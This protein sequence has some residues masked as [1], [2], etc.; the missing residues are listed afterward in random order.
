MTF[1]EYVNAR[2]RRRQ[3]RWELR[4]LSAAHRVA[5]GLAFRWPDARGW[6]G[7]GIYVLVGWVI[8]LYVSI[9]AL[10]DDE[11][12]KTIA[13]LIVG[14]AFVNSVVQWAFGAT[15]GGGELAQ[16]NADTIATTA[17]PLALGSEIA[18][19]RPKGTPEDPIATEEVR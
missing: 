7:I 12:F 5:A 8:G 18:P 3:R 15:K 11:F 14:T 10:R 9:E 16:K 4:R 13:T 6:V 2:A 1:W 17:R 19:D